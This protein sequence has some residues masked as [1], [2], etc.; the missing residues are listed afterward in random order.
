MNVT[1]AAIMIA[2]IVV[3]RTNMP[4]DLPFNEAAEKIRLAR[5]NDWEQILLACESVKGIKDEDGDRLS[6]ENLAELALTKI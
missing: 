6:N 4:N 2:H 1:F 5:P 3:F